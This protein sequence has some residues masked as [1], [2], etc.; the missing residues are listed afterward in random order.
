MEET[1][2]REKSSLKGLIFGLITF[3]LITTLLIG[4]IYFFKNRNDESYSEEV[5][6]EQSEEKIASIEIF[7]D[8]ETKDIYDVE[9]QEGQS[10]FQ[11]LE[12]L[13]ANEE[14]QFEYGEFEGLG[15]FVTSL[16]GITADSNSEYWKFLINGEEAQVG[17]SDYI[18]QTG[19]TIQFEIEKFI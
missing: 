10:V 13:K 4:S 6:F 14:I 9:I 15:V 5:E 8:S 12:T 7:S 16:N 17:I 2:S 19:D 11:I 18:I 3:I 1:N